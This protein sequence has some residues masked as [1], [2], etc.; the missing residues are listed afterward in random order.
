MN[1][2]QQVQVRRRRTR[3]EIRQLE[4]EFVSG[5]M[6]R[7]EFC[8]RRGLSFGMLARHLKRQ[9]WK[10]K[11]GSTSTAGRDQTRLKRMLSQADVML[12]KYIRAQLALAGLSFA[13]YTICMLV[14]GFR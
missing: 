8:R 9:Q 13:L 11:T 14:L 12:A 2:E 10:K 6:R 1:V 4:A 5:G 7:S 3:A